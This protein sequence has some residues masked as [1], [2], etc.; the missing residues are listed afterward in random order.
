MV[1]INTNIASLQAQNSLN[2]NNDRVSMAIERLSTGLKINSAADNAAGLAISARMVAVSKA[3]S[4]AEGNANDGVSLIKTADGSLA[5]ST[6]VLQRM[7]ELATQSANVTNSAS[8][9]QAIASEVNQLL[10]ELNNIAANTN[11]NG[12]NLLNG[13]FTSQNFQVGVT[14]SETISLSI[15]SAKTDDIGNNRLNQ[16]NATTNQGSSSVTAATTNAPS[17]NAIGT[18]TLTVSGGLGSSSVSVTAGDSAFTIATNVNSNTSSTGVTATAYNETQIG[19]LSADGT[20]TLTLGSGSSTSS[21]SGSVTTTDMSAL[22]AAIN[23]KTGTTGVSATYSGGTLNLVQADGKDIQITDFT[24]SNTSSD[25]TAYIRAV[26]RSD[27]DSDG[28]DDITYGT[29]S[30]LT[31]D[32]GTPGASTNNTTAAGAVYFDSSNSFSVTSSVTAA[33]G[34]VLDSAAAQGSTSEALA[35]I[36]VSTADAAKSAMR[37]ID[38]ALDKINAQ[39]ASLGSSQNRL[40]IAISNI[41]TTNINIQSAASQIKDADFSVETA[42]LAKGQILSQAATAML[43]QA[44]QLP[45]GVLQL[46]G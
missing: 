33:A 14:A 29:K 28:I 25:T 2:K 31:Y 43:A 5:A 30:T 37:V 11:F 42:N 4:A 46:I 34:S 45:Q 38:A 44:N 9:R 16:V 21:I 10:Q 6:N 32:S 26:R 7:K 8:D 22:A 24:H 12:L 17:T 13:T 40:G 39:R 3:L 27:N 41:N 18:Q 36:S 1:S 23:D 15:S 19:S 35:N 20:V